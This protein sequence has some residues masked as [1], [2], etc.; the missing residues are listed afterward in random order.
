LPS[1]YVDFAPVNME[2]SCESCQSLVFDRSASGALRTLSHGDVGQVMAE[3]AGMNRGPRGDIVSSRSRPGQFARGGRYHSNFGR[4]L[5]AYVAITRALQP[6]GVCSECHI[7]TTT[8]GQ[9]DITPVNLPHRFLVSGGFNHAAHGEDVAEGGC[10]DCHAT[11]TSSEASDLLIPDLASCRDCHQGESA[12]QT[13][14]ITPSTCAMCH[15][16]HVPSAPWKPE[17]HPNL[18]GNDGNET[19]AAFIG[20]LRP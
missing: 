13:E 1:D 12:I 15:G 14:Q 16:Y 7:P 8:D 18:P 20:S 9:L 6:G 17:D 2:A 11:S 19:V 3:L 5:G 10:V 4:P